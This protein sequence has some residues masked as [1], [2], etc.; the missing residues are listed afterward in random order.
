MNIDQKILV[1]RF[2][3]I[4]DI[5][6]AT[7][8]LKTI[9]KKFPKAEITF[10]TLDTYA[11]LLEYHPDIDILIS[12][13]KNNRIY[14]LYKFS[15]F[16][17]NNN[18]TII[19]D[20]HNSLRSRFITFG[21][22]RKVKRVIKPRLNRILLFYFFYSRFNKNFS[23]LKMYHSCLGNIWNNKDQIYPTL[24]KLSKWEKNKSLELLELYGISN[25]LYFAI[26][27]GAAWF[28][29]CWNENKYVELIKRLDVPVVLLGLKSDI[30]CFK[31]S[32]KINN[33]IN[34]AGK[35]NLRESMS[36]ISS[37]SYVIGSDTGLTHI[38][39]AFGKNVS[40]IL[41][42]TSF[43]TGANVISINSKI[44]EKKIWCRPCS[45]NGKRKCYRKKQFC[46]DL[47]SVD[48]VFN[49]IPNIK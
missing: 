11:S 48:D 14:D 18:Y 33:V 42:P 24:L 35:T 47:I 10:L 26:I 41:G 19:F 23:V 4:G 38:A 27:P 37:A 29:K 1:I 31:I 30:I 15:K 6:L 25:K 49:S 12:L 28:Q 3:S 9:R 45:Q 36:I 16:I 13:K 22:K 8:P 7:S 2:S 34:L 20:L 40:M 32:K 39:E 17:R 5:V 46:M 44:I 21:L 43:E